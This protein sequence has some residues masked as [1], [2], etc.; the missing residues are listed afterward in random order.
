MTI[1]DV[2]PE[3]KKPEAQQVGLR[4]FVHEALTPIADGKS[5]IINSSFRA[6]PHRNGYTHRLRFGFASG[7]RD[8]AYARLYG[9]TE[10]GVTVDEF[11]Y[12]GLKGL[13]EEIEEQHDRV[14]VAVEGDRI[15]VS[16]M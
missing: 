11:H 3:V 2:E 15:V 5:I 14:R 1:T 9:A 7:G 6:I 16:S 4:R 8:F 13:A 10:G 12:S